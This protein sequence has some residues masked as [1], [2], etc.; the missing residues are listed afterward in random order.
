ML[1]VNSGLATTLMGLLANSTKDKTHPSQYPG[2]TEQIRSSDTKLTQT[3]SQL[4]VLLL[5]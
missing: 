3:T 2:E 5:L 1:W 4:P